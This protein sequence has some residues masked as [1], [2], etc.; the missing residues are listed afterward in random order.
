LFTIL[1]LQYNY[2]CS[3]SY[4]VFSLQFEVQKVYED[5]C[6]VLGGPKGSAKTLLVRKVPQKGSPRFSKR[7]CP[8]LLA[9]SLFI[10]PIFGRSLSDCHFRRLL[11]FSSLLLFNILVHKCTKPVSFD[12]YPVSPTLVSLTIPLDLYCLRS[13]TYSLHVT[14]I[15]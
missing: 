12:I 10:S 6:Y 2:K 9:I 3:C 1:I 4:S 5:T 8:S 14:L 15:S 13:Y 7:F 11:T